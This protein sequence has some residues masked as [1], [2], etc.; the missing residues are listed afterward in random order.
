MCFETL[1]G[2]G[3]TMRALQGVYFETLD[4]AGARP[5]AIQPPFKGSMMMELRRVSIFLYVLRDARWGR[6][7][8]ARSSRG[9]LRDA[10]W[11][12]RETICNTTA[13]QGEHDDGT[14]ARIHFSLCA[15][16]RSMG[17]ARPCA[18]F[19]GCT[20][21]RSMAPARDH[22]QYNRSSRGA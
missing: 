9:V 4:G 5:Y 14:T 7:D 11:R 6:R 19:K 1:D 8:H 22:M 2:A 12:R 15:S 21:R 13:L 18:L 16:R 17:P 3:E 20:S 10:R